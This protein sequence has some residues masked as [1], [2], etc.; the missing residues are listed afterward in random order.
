MFCRRFYTV[1]QKTEP[2]CNIMAV[3]VQPL[4][5]D[6]VIFFIFVQMLILQMWC[7]GTPAKYAI[8][9]VVGIIEKFQS[10]NL[11]IPPP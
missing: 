8:F 5:S 6:I 1:S 4:S 2:L 11:G 3:L 9:F 10:Q 7:A